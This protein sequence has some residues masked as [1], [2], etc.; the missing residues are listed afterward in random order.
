[1]QLLTWKEYLGAM[2][3]TDV[4]AYYTKLYGNYAKA[5]AIVNYNMNERAVVGIDNHFSLI[6]DIN[7]I[8]FGQ[9][10]S[11]ERALTSGLP[12]HIALDLLAKA[13]IRPKG[14]KVFDNTDENKESLLESMI[15]YS[16]ASEILSEI[17]KYTELR[18]DFIN[19]KY[20]GVFYL[21]N[22]EKIAEQE[23]E[24]QDVPT[25]QETA[26]KNF[27]KQWY[28][29]SIVRSLANEDISRYEEILMTEM[30]VIAPEL[31]YKR[32]K[33]II[34]EAREKVR[35]AKNM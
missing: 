28:W 16:E 11:A 19:V 25:A 5:A 29:Y 13:V 14:D 7:K 21:P 26:E 31:A 2:A 23:S 4:L 35:R 24:E 8:V 18:N 9:F 27:E 34:E 32:H 33:Q 20:N 17:E 22:R 1:M 3:S 15:Y 30:G 6:R 12:N 10:I